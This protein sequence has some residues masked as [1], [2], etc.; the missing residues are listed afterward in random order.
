MVRT[1]L[2][3]GFVVMWSVVVGLPALVVSVVTLG[4]LRRHLIRPVARAWARPILAVARA[5]VEVRGAEHLAGRAARV[6]VVNHTS[7]VDTFVMAALAPDH[8]VPFVKREF[9]WTPLLGQV[10]WAL[11][12]VYVDRS[13]GRRALEVL[14]G[15]AGQL[16]DGRL[17]A[18]IAPEGTRSRS[19]EVQPF[20]RGAFLLAQRAGAPVVPV[21]IHGAWRLM[22]PGS[23]RIARG[24]LVVEI[25]P[26]REVPPSADAKA[27]ARDLYL[28]YQTWLR[29]GPGPA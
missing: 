7:F 24:R 1:A 3:W 13:H 15:V 9:S 14:E 16:R 8:M 29:A 4:R 6:V 20:K 22:T 21:V 10:F 26:P 17:T 23:L 12:A 25:H 18:M 5:R 27:Y 2:L 11:G 28:Q 19:G